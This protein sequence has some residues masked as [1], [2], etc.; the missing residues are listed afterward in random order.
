MA[1]CA[2][3]NFTESDREIS[4]PVA[5]VLE[6][7]MDHSKKW[8]LPQWRL[9]AIVTGEH[10][11]QHHQKVLIHQDEIRS[12]FYWGGMVLHLYKDGSE[13]YWYN[14]LSKT[15]YLFVICDGEEGEMEIDPGFVTANQ[16]EAT[17]YMES[18]RMV[19]SIAMPAEIRDILE[20]YVISHYFPRQK[21]KRKRQNWAENTAYA[22]EPGQKS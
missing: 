10:I 14:L 9:F 21:K 4:I 12:R 16:D 2:P 3:V 20:R 15:P 11:R 13:G 5:V 17:G 6:R 7:A 8:V 18:D 22:K 1:S 19:L